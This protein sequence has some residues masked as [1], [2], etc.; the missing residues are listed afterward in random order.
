MSKSYAAIA[1]NALFY[2][3]L[4]VESCVAS[5][6]IHHLHA[7]PGLRCYSNYAS[8]IPLFEQMGTRA[9]R[10][11]NLFTGISNKKFITIY[12]YIVLTIVVLCTDKFAQISKNVLTL[13]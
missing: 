4:L 10:Y 8:E 5:L 7:R 3:K 9:Q 6:I 1:N 13:T 2:S 12:R 11:Q